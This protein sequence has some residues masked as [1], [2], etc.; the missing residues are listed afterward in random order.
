[1][2][3]HDPPH[4]GEVFR[5]LHVEPL[6]L[7]VSE[8]ARR[9]GIARKT[10]SLLVNGRAGIS[11]EMA[12]RI[13]LATGTTAESW[14]GMQAYYDLWRTRQKKKKLKVHPLAA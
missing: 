13:S 9:L 1:M 10:M 11:P 7:T 4:P 5:R 14:L 6:K 3:M 8:A 12:I 2:E